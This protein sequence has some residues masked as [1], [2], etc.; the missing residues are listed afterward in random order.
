MPLARTFARLENLDMKPFALENLW[1]HG[2]GQVVDVDDLHALDAGD[3]VQVEIVR[4]DPGV[5][6]HRQFDQL[7]IHAF[8]IGKRDLMDFDAG[9]LALLD[10]TRVE[11]AD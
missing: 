6:A 2:V 10:P 11:R 4:H 3:L 7:G 5:H 1:P 8:D 9:V